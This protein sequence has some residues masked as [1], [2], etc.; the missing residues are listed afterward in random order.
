V[1]MVLIFSAT[2]LG[3]LDYKFI[4]VN[5]TYLWSGIVGGLIMGFGFIIGGFCPG[6]S[7][8]ALATLKIDGFFFA[9]GVLIGIF[10]FGESVSTFE[11]FWNA[12]F[13]GRYTL[14]EWLGISTGATVLIVVAMAI[15][16]FWGG[17]KL[18]GIFGEKRAKQPASMKLLGAGALVVLAISVLAVGQPTADDRWEWIEADKQPL[19]SDRAI[20]IHPGELAGL[21]H[22]DQINLVMLDLR[23]ERDFNLFHLKEAHLLD[24]RTLEQQIDWLLEAPANTVFMLIGND[25][26]TATEGWKTLTASGVANV[27]V[28]EGGMNNWL[29]VFGHPGHEYCAT[30]QRK[31]DGTLRHHFSIAL[32]DRY[33]SAAP[34]PH[35]LP[36]GLKFVSKVQL[37]QKRNK[38]S[39]GCG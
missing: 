32:G 22:D 6:T 33:S 11:G 13:L 23:D 26:Q 30:A 31:A 2:G 21:M 37:Q 36:E 8:V 14:P 24:P 5:P 20:Q 35:E 29:A 34:D 3:F 12:G 17:E 10:G 39:G 38:A 4:W 15:F 25:E 1:A 27:Y 7:L 9:F 16:M 28:L 19:I 18:E